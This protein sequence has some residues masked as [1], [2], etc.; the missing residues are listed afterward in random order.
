M[1]HRANTAV[2]STGRYHNDLD[3]CGLT[4][5]C[6][7]HA[8]SVCY[9]AAPKYFLKEIASLKKGENSVFE[10]LPNNEGFRLRHGVSFHLFVTKF[11]CGFIGQQK[12]PCMEW[13]IPFV[14]FPHVP[15][16]SSRFLIGATMGIQGYISHLLDKPIMIDSLV[17]LC[18]DI[19]KN[20]PF[21]FDSSFRMPVI[22][23]MK[24]D[25]EDFMPGFFLPSKH[26]LNTRFSEYENDHNL[27]SHESTDGNET[28]VSLGPG[29]E[30]VEESS[31][32]VTT[33]ERCARSAF[34]TFSSRST[35]E[36]CSHDDFSIKTRDIDPSFEVDE[37]LKLRRISDMKDLYNNLI[38]QLKVEE[39][40]E[41]LHTKLHAEIKKKDEAM[42]LLIQ[43][44]STELTEVM[45]DT[46]NTTS[47]QEWNDYM[48]KQVE[49]R[50][51]LIKEDGKTK[52]K[53]HNMLMCIKTILTT[54]K[55]NIIMDCSWHQ[56]LHATQSSFQPTSDDE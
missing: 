53:N 9:E 35:K 14:E 39:A 16:C 7:G 29:S 51:R 3:K 15:T 40:L 47:I 19:D 42:S 20:Q 34:V 6:E 25:P 45:P 37:E 22:K 28:A 30:G 27:V 24:Y 21:N 54:K 31:V 8:V 2:L 49:T 13:K 33:P 5:T 52:I 12:E 26:D 43:S 48:R 50:V 46:S 44:V 36:N 1:G 10:L 41:M 18:N 17:I 11:P 4:T 55:E 38:I 32:I 23:T 56:Y